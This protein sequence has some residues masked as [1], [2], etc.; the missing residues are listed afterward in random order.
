MHILSNENTTVFKHSSLKFLSSFHGIR[1][2]KKTN[3][4]TPLNSFTDGLIS[5]VTGINSVGKI[6]TDGFT[7]RTRLSV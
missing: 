2:P 5:S 3:V 4:T 6:I 1:A 7:N